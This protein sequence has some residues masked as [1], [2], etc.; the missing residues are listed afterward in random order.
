M[1]PQIHLIDETWIDASSE[2]VSAV[3][4]NPANWRV[5]WPTLRLDVTRDRGRKGMQWAAR[6]DEVT[7]TAEIWLEPYKTG[8]ILHHYLRL[9]AAGGRPLRARAARRRTRAFAEQAKRSFWVLKDELER[10]TGSGTGH[11]AAARR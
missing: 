5:W 2:T 7:G 1:Q 8:V 3:I 9:D 6:S 11:A 4:A 10:D